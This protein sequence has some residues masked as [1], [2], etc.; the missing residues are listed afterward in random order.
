MEKEITKNYS[1]GEVTI[2][3]R[4]SKCI[5]SGICVK[6][7]PGVFNVNKRP[8]IEVTAASTDALIDQVIKCPSGALSYSM[9]AT[10]DDEKRNKKN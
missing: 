2:H 5:H 7:L 6:G 4:P 1:N 9:N 3:W 8:W 10:T